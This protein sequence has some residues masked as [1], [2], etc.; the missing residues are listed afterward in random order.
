MRVV[1]GLFETLLCPSL[2]AYKRYGRSLFFLTI[3]HHRLCDIFVQ[4]H[5]WIRRC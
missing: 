2:H 1:S 3:R 5:A 4:E